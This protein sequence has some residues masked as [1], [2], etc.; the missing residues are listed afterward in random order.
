MSLMQRIKQPL[1]TGA[2]DGIATAA[3]MARINQHCNPPLSAEDV[4][5]FPCVMASRQ[6]RRDRN[7]SF[8]D[9]SLKQF[10]KDADAGVPYLLSHEDSHAIG[11]YTYAGYWDA[12]TGQARAAVFLKRGAKMDGGAWSDV[13][14]TTDDE[15]GA[16][17]S[18]LRRSVSV[19][20]TGGSAVLTCNICNQPYYGGDCPHFFGEVYDNVVCTGVYE[21]C[22]LAELSGVYAGA[23]PDALIGASLEQMQKKL[24]ASLNS[25]N[26]NA[27]KRAQKE[28]SMSDQT[29]PAPT[30]MTLGARLAAMTGWNKLAASVLGAKDD[31]P[32]GIADGIKAGVSAQVEEQVQSQLA[33]HPLLSACTAAGITTPEQLSASLALAAAGRKYEAQINEALK[34]AAIRAHGEKS[35]EKLAAANVLPLD[36]KEATIAAWN[37]LADAK[38]RVGE[39]RTSNP[40]NTD[41]SAKI[42]ADHARLAPKSTKED[43]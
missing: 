27:P 11:G 4:F 33:A 6:L 20:P 24:A 29:N 37:E 5:V 34:A 14:W 35:P 17:Q 15:I 12:Q 42:A 40:T 18:G 32:E 19:G 43:K 16:I 36:D 23:I 38:L 31:T 10:A 1:G 8:G 39:A 26:D 22:G 2:P 28:R 9:S 13:E 41:E 7:W 3:D 25:P 21:G 30:R